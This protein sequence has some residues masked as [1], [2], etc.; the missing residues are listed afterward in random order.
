MKCV[1]TAL[2]LQRAGLR[3]QRKTAEVHVAG[4]CHCHSVQHRNNISL[5]ISLW[6]T[7]GTQ[8]HA[9][10]CDAGCQVPPP[11]SRSSKLSH[12]SWVH[13]LMFLETSMVRNAETEPDACMLLLFI[14][15]IIPS[16]VRISNNCLP[17]W[18]RKTNN[19]L[20]IT[21]WRKNVVISSQR[22]SLT[23]TSV[24]FRPKTL[25]LDWEQEHRTH[26][27]DYLILSLEKSSRPS[28]ASPRHCSTG[29]ECRYRWGGPE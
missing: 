13:T 19:I 12:Y 2:Q 29:G 11:G 21:F 17:V 10:P 5:L 18:T 22:K 15:S 26:R 20:G 16:S 27:D 25:L 8:A 24:Y 23:H 4:C 7:S 14:S 3:I 28:S 9:T 1:L 6:I